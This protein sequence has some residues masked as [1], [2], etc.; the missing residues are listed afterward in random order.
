MRR[1]PHSVLIKEGFEGQR[2]PHNGS[3]ST[4]KQQSPGPR[5]SSVRVHVIWSQG[6]EAH[7]RLGTQRNN[8]SNTKQDQA[9][10]E[11]DAQ[12]MTMGLLLRE[13]EIGEQEQD[14][15]D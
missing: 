13:D 5:T 6:I 10:R 11:A 1:H 7:I 8:E 4:G 2:T 9:D 14:I 3:H 12:I 15:A